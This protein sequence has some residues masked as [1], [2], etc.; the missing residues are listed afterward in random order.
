MASFSGGKSQ[1]NVDFLQYSGSFPF[2]NCLLTAQSWFYVTGGGVVDPSTLDSNGYPTSIVN[3]GVATVFFIPTQAEYAGNYT[4]T[5]DAANAGAQVVIPGVGTYT[6]AGAGPQSF[7]A[8][9]ANLAALNQTSYS[10]NGTNTVCRVQL[11]VTAT[12][13]SN[14]HFFNV[15]D[16]SA[17]AAAIA[18]GLTWGGFGQLFLSSLAASKPGVIRFLNWQGTNVYNSTFW[19][20]RRPTS[21]YSFFDGHMAPSQACGSTAGA[22]DTFTITGNGT[23]VPASGAPTDKLTVIANLNHAGSTTANALNLNGTGAVTFVT[24]QGA[25]TVVSSGWSTL[26]YD[27]ALNAWMVFAGTSGIDDGCPPEVMAELAYEIG[28]H[29][30]FVTPPYA[31]AP[32]TDYMSSLASYIKTTYQDSGKA[33]WMVPRFE[34]PNE[35]WNTVTNIANYSA[36][37]ATK[38]WNSADGGA[39]GGDNYWYGYGLSLMGQGLL[40]VWG[41]PGKY[42]VLCGVQSSSYKSGTQFSNPR[43]NCVR[44][45]GFLAATFAGGGS[46]NITITGNAL[47]A[48]APVQFNGASIPSGLTANATYYVKTTGTTITISASPGGTALT[49]STAGSGMVQ[50]NATT[51]PAYNWATHVACTCYINPFVQNAATELQNAYDYYITYAGNSVQ[52]AAVVASYVATNDVRYAVING[53]ISGATLTVNSTSSGGIIANTGVLLGAGVA[54]NTTVAGG[55]GSTFTVSPSQ[56]VGPVTMTQ[57][58]L[59]KSYQAWQA[60]GASF[61]NPVSKVTNYEGGWSPDYVADVGTAPHVTV[62]VT[63]ATNA[64]PCVLTITT[65]STSYFGNPGLANMPSYSANMWIN[66]PF[67]GAWAGLASWY[68]ITSGNDTSITIQLDATAMVSNFAA[69]VAGEYAFSV[70]SST[71]TVSGTSLTVS[72]FSGDPIVIGSTVFYAASNFTGVNGYGKVTAFG[73]GTGG[74]G[75]YTLDR[76]PG[77]ASS[78]AGTIKLDTWWA[79]NTLRYASK[80]SP[81]LVPMLIQNYTDVTTNTMSGEFPSCF[82]FGNVG[83][84]GIADPDIYSLSSSPQYTG[85]QLFNNNKRRLRILT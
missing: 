20:L 13:V 8:T 12:G 33:S 81:A 58:G 53:T 41:S 18:N 34:G 26:I 40:S 15:N 84:W 82:S 28:A 44:A 76:S 60:W 11:N 57:D 42:Q 3:G 39:G 22:G 31:F 69:T 5:F 47:A 64:N 68:K 48:N 6:A 29:P 9:A 62:S 27:A 70:S 52:Q 10:Y 21:Y 55:S 50:I 17:R 59:L 75:T 51:S 61:A 24:G 1:V 83:V 36:A 74:N 23:G 63:G 85:I 19:A 7:T 80:F 46:A 78:V 71:I 4:L 56:T 16:A 79:V 72:G 38:W 66:V 45:T 32:L 2:I 35:S 54:Y 14:V 67:T 25:A 30:Y 77:D 37:V 43:L 65:S 49:F 73:S